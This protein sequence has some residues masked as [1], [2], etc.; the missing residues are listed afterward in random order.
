[1][2]IKTFDAIAFFKDNAGLFTVSNLFLFISLYVSSYI[3]SPN[4]VDNNLKIL[5]QSL[6]FVSAITVL[7]I[8][9]YITVLLWNG[10]KDEISTY[11]FFNNKIK[12]KESDPIRI[13]IYSMLTLVVAFYLGFILY[14]GNP[15]ISIASGLLILLVP[16]IIQGIFLR[17]SLKSIQDFDKIDA[18][19]DFLGQQFETCYEDW[20]FVEDKEDTPLEIYEIIFNNLRE[21]RDRIQYLD[22]MLRRNRIYRHKNPQY[23]GKFLKESLSICDRL[24]ASDIRELAK[25]FMSQ[26]EVIANRDLENMDHSSI[27]NLYNEIEEIENKI[28][29]LADTSQKIALMWGNE[30]PLLNNLSEKISKDHNSI[31]KAKS[32]IEGTMTEAYLRKYYFFGT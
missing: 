29:L 25:K 26:F 8:F 23:D 14:S 22:D 11:F 6:I 30:Y 3:N 20:F 1:M 4:S 19:W 18:E 5:G 12:I 28:Q 32:S 21:H 10:R 17:I 13:L 2:E 16:S 15:Y 27:K 7:F 9:T 31:C 24:I